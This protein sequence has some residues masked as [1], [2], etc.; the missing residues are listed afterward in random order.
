MSSCQH[1]VHEPKDLFFLP[2]LQSQ[3]MTDLKPERP[4]GFRLYSCRMSYEAKDRKKSTL[5]NS[6]FRGDSQGV[7]NKEE[8]SRGWSHHK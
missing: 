4:I 8:P 5:L 1:C 6:H 3:Q 7:R 2:Q